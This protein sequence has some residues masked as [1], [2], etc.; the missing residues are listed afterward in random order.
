MQ[1]FSLDKENM[2]KYGKA[3]RP[4]S[5]Q[6]GREGGRRDCG[7]QCGNPSSYPEQNSQPE[8]TERCYLSRCGWAHRDKLGWL[9]PPW[10]RSSDRTWGTERTPTPERVKSTCQKCKP[11]TGCRPST[12]CTFLPLQRW[13]ASRHWADRSHAGGC[14]GNQ[15]RLPS[16]LRCYQPFQQINKLYAHVINTTKCIRNKSR[17]SII[18]KCPTIIILE[19]LAGLK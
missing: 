15:H 10:W 17:T 5:R 3:D 4:G 11:V 13:R 19:I 7:V 14:G 16:S 2:T 18:M 12:A 1:H 6:T 8:R 9:P